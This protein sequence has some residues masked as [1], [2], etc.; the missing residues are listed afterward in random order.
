[1]TA[2]EIDGAEQRYGLRFPP[3]YRLFLGTLHTPDPEMQGAGYEGGQFA[4]RDGRWLTDWAGDPREIVRWLRWPLEGLLW[5]IEVN[6]G[7]HPNWGPRPDTQ[8]G[9]EAAV[10]EFATASPQLVPIGHHHY[11]VGPPDIA[12]N[13]VLSTYGHDVIVYASN[14]VQYLPIVCGLDATERAGGDP[15]E[16]GKSIPFWADVIEGGLPG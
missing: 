5:S 15:Q 14:L 7:W 16:I 9:R 2:D 3:D 13:P 11:L 8:A 4:E 6:N 10:R 12:G 1:M